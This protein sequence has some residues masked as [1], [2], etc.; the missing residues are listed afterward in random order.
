MN[1]RSG[2]IHTIAA[3]IGLIAAVAVIVAVLTG[4]GHHTAAI[5]AHDCPPGTHWA[6]VSP[7]IHGCIHSVWHASSW[8]WPWD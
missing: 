5:G 6:Y 1:N 8:H 7:A 2:A 3:V 4:C